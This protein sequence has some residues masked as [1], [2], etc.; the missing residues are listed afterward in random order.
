MTREQLTLF[1]GLLAGAALL[2]GAAVVLLLRE[3]EARDLRFRIQAVTRAS[4]RAA[5]PGD[6]QGNGRPPS[7]VIV[8]V[9]QFGEWLRNSGRV[10]SAKDIGVL[11]AIITASGF[12]PRKLLPLILGAKLLFL[13]VSLAVGIVVGVVTDATFGRWNV[14]MALALLAGIGVPEIAL[15]VM[16]R[17]HANALRRGVPDALDLLVVCTEAGLGLESALEQ[18]SREMHRSNRAIAVALANFLDELRVLPDRR[19]AFMNFGRKSGVDGIRR[20]AIVLSQAMRLGTPLGHA[21]RSMAIELRRDQMVRLEEKAVRLPALLVF[22]LIFCILPTLLIVL[23]GPS[24]LSLIDT[25]HNV[26]MNM[27]GH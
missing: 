13:V 5:T 16:R 25:L 18:V 2:V 11:E 23:V 22:P 10:Y 21:L 27:V 19:E 7:S 14:L 8:L 4:S 9:S 1:V 17:S 6:I 15:N 26:H 3:A 20:M 12:R 24:A